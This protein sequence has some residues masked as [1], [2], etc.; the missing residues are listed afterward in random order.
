M[1]SAAE[2]AESFAT[3]E[4]VAA[5]SEFA[6]DATPETRDDTLVESA[7]DSAEST[8]AREDVAD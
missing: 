3:R 6:T 2:S 4:D 8:A 7:S 5:D 1:E